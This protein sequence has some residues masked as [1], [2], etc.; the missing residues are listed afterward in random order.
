MNSGK[1]GL[2]KNRTYEAPISA[3]YVVSASYAVSASHATTA[4]NSTTSGNTIAID[5]SSFGANLDSYLLMSNVIG[6]SG[7]GI[8]GDTDL[9]YNSYTNVLTVPNISATTLTG[10]LQGTASYATNAESV[11]TL[12][13][14]SGSAVSFSGTPRT[15]SFTFTS[16]YSNNNYAV[17]VTGEDA[18]TWTIQSKSSTGFTINSNSSVALTGPVYWIATPFNS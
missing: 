5:I 15:A 12:K 11:N 14:G 8:G 16:A 6:T 17:N 9:M 3:S 13:A 4:D 2:P 7:V 1:Y 10:S 18:R